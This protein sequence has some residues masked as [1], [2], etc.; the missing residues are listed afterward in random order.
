MNTF[1]A[2]PIEELEVEVDANVD[3]DFEVTVYARLIGESFRR[4]L[5]DQYIDAF[6]GPGGST[7]RLTA[8]QIQQ[9]PVA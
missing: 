1:V 7:T 8:P 5:V 4:R 2:A 6:D 3:G 9:A